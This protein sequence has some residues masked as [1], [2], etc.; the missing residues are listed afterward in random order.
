VTCTPAC[1]LAPN[2]PE[3]IAVR[4]VQGLGGAIVLPLALRLLPGSY[5]ASE[6]LDLLGV[7]FLTGSVIAIVWALVRASQAGWTSAEIIG[8]LAA[9]VVLLVAFVAREQRAS[10][11]MVPLRLFRS[12]AFA[13]GNAASF[14]MSGAIFAASF[15]MSGAIFAAGVLV[16]K[17]FQLARGYSPVAAGLRLLASLLRHADGQLAGRRGQL[18]LRRVR[19]PGHAR[20]R[21]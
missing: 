10:Q 17:E 9:G 1:A 8:C 7:T 4:T 6:R 18:C 14:L 2:V 5:G 16:T 13:A 21:H 3:L 12:R 19:P 11:P 20:E 15:L